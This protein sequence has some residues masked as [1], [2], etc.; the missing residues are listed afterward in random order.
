MDIVNSKWPSNITKAVISLQSQST[1]NQSTDNE[2][3]VSVSSLALRLTTA[4]HSLNESQTIPPWD[5]N[6]IISVNESETASAKS[7]F[8]D[9]SK[10]ELETIALDLSNTFT[11]AEKV[12][13]YDQWHVLD[14]IELSNLKRE[15]LESVDM[16]SLFE[17][18]LSSHIGSFS[19]FSAAMISDEYS[20]QATSQ[21]KFTLNELGLDT[22]K[23]DDQSE[24]YYDVMIEELFGGREL[25]VQS[26]VNGMSLSNVMRSPLEFLTQGDRDLLADMYE[27]ADKND[28]DFDYIS[29]LAIDLGDYRKH[30]NG[31]LMSSRT[32]LLDMDGHKLSF[33]F[34]EKDQTTIDSLLDSDALALTGIDQGFISFITD[35]GFGP[36]SHEGNY[37]FLQHM[38][39]VTAGVETTL[40][41]EEF[42][43]FEGFSGIEDRYIR[44]ASEEVFPMPEPDVVCK[45]GHCEVTEKG[46]Q[47]GVTLDNDKGTMPTFDKLHNSFLEQR[48]HPETQDKLWFKWLV[49][50]SEKQIQ[51]KE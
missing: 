28:V 22:S 20:T 35:P 38:V 4:Q 47:N 32:N 18:S 16:M 30:D 9:L 5:N 50:N 23:T 25:E 39:E 37:Q 40:S 2:T 33:N 7:L 10:D 27:Y 45:N 31:N 34:I 14:Q 51:N 11:D 3:G 19:S 13:A 8:L 42:K 15:A 24:H 41:P 49:A 48:T 46:H 29:R 26:G 44:T 1:V 6:K 17:E 12:A 21:F 43:I 36:L